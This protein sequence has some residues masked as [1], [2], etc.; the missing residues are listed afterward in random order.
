VTGAKIADGT[1]DSRDI[2]RFS[3][4]FRT[5]VGPVAAGKC[6]SGEP[7]GLAPEAAKADISGDLVLVTPDA[8][9]P[10][11]RLAFTVRGSANPSRFVLAAC[12]VTTSSV[13]ATEIG[14]RY[15]V[16]DLP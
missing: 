10:E 1:L 14:F 3:G 15:V 5:T 13:P 8:S 11:D 7:V 2:A 12:N 4:R 16:L 9:W 6:W